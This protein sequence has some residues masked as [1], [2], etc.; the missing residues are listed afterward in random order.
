[1]SKENSS[2]SDEELNKSYNFLEDIKGHLEILSFETKIHDIYNPE[3]SRN[4]SPRIAQSRNRCFSL[5][6]KKKIL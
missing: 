6:Y 2:Q 3:H 1:M 5:N 4:I